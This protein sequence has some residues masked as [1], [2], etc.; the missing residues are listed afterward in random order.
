[1]PLFRTTL[2]TKEK[3][4]LISN[5]ATML[6]AGIPIYEAT[7]VLLDE[8]KGT[9]QIILQQ[10]QK[11]LSAGKAINVSFANFPYVF[12]DVTINLIHAAEEAGTLEETLRDL[13]DT[14]RK[15]MEFSERVR[16]AMMYPIIIFI[17]FIGVVLLMLIV[18]IPKISQV[19]ERMKVDLP[20]PTRIMVRS[21]N[22]LLENTYP[23][24][25][26]VALAVVIIAILYK[27]N[28]QFILN[29][30]FSVPGVRGLVRQIDIT[31]FCRSLHL[32]LS[33]GVPITHSLALAQKVVV[34]K[35]VSQ[36]IEKARTLAESGHQFSEGLKT[37]DKIFPPMMVKLMEVGERTGQ[38]ENSMLHVSEQMDYEVSKTLK[39]L[40]SMIEPIMLVFIG[41]AVGG[42]MM[43]IISPI[44]GLIGNVG[45]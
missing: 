5:L 4:N 19:F 37:K 36:I 38:L 15:E 14:M 13:V 2:S 11:D 24:I 18:V 42:M 22:L 16:S 9:T 43:G 21:S 3:M 12:D 26:G 41:L 10:L 17:V 34:K 6:Q 28:K 32:L 39:A 40:T 44:Y 33:S 30:I 29:M 25:G 45:G 1:M 27:R 23:V 7:E 35:E 31:R 20:L 8:A